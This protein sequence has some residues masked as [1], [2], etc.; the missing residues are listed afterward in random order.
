MPVMI[1]L[2]VL[3]VAG[4]AFYARLWRS[5]RT[6]EG[7]SSEGFA[8]PD[9]ITA[10]LLSFWFISLIAQSSGGPMQV[11]VSTIIASGVIYLGIV[12]FLLAALSVRKV[13]Y[14]NLWGLRWP[15]WKSGLRTV[16]IGF[17]AILPIVAVMQWIAAS[18]AGQ[19]KESQPLLD[20]WMASENPMHRLLIIAMAV[21]VAPLAEETIFRGYLYGVAK[22]Y[23]GRVWALVAVSLLFAAIHMHL[24]AFAGLFVLAVALTIIY[25]FTGALWAP[26]LMHALFNATSLILSLTWPDLA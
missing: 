2:A 21:V 24:P 13:A 14:W 12:G 15:G 25:E 6:G 19:G 16:G 26:M 9:V 18:L 20:F 3:A 5:L 4:L 1:L 8:R 11:S 7:I 17:L 23:V 22:K 10:C